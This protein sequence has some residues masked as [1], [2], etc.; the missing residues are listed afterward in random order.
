M[1][2]ETH[3]R[4]FGGRQGQ[5]ALLAVLNLTVVFGA[6]GFAVDLGLGQFKKHAEQAA[7]DAAALAAA[8]YAQDNSK[9]CASGITCNVVTNCTIPVTVTTPFGAACVYAKA[10]GYTNGGSGGQTVTIFANNTGSPVTGNTPSLWFKATVGESYSP[11]FASF[12][13]VSALT[14][15]A[16]ALAGTTTNGGGSCV[17][18]LS[19]AAGN[20]FSS[21]GSGNVTTSATCGI[22]DNGG[23]NFNGVRKY[24]R[25]NHS[26]P[27]HLFQSRFRNYQPTRRPKLRLLSPILS[28]V[29]HRLPFSATCDYTNFKITRRWRHSRF[30]GSLL[31]RLQDE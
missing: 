5:A 28:P 11:L 26:V 24:Q 25:G 1:K 14:S 18:A 22:Y 31:R 19:Q 10:N 21:S 23:F 29:C 27:G 7:A 9:T 20:S 4:R 30:T 13:G 15:H 17:I 8:S 16:S 6:I 3:I 12:G 2:P